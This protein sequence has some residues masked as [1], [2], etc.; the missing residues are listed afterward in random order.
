MTENSLIID[1]HILICSVGRTSTEVEPS[2]VKPHSVSRTP[3]GGEENNIMQVELDY[4]KNNFCG[5]V[6]TTIDGVIVT[7]QY[8][9]LCGDIRKNENI[10]SANVYVIKQLSNNYNMTTYNIIDIGEVP[11][12]IHNV[13]IYFRNIFNSNDKDYFNSIKTSHEFQSLTES[14]KPNSAFRTGIYLTKV[15][16]RDAE[17]KFNLLRCSSNLNGPTDNFRDIDNEIITKINTVTQIHFEQKVELNHVLAQI[18]E[19]NEKGKAKI[20]AHSDKTKDM[21]ANALMA[22]CTFYDTNLIN[23]KIKKS[24][25]DMFDY[26]Y[27]KTSVLTKLH[28]KLKYPVKYPLLAKEFSVTLYPNSAFIIS[29]TTNRLY[30][31]E[32]RPSVL[33]FNVIP[34]RMG[35][36]IRCSNTPAIF[37]DGQTWIS[38][39]DEYTPL[40]KINKD[41]ANELRTQYFKENTT[42]DIIEYAHTKFSMNSGDYLEPI[43]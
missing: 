31:H 25:T 22:F 12:N 1:K 39:N 5:I 42:D 4:L 28:F 21:P 40:E 30:T 43:F 35:Y 27:N 20:K 29:L 16:K 3:V 10:K 18:Y 37:K 23:N 7:D 17:L 36:V 8:I 11:I 6:L 9:Y 19:N 13:G 34:T 41:G 33:P 15:E 24:N 2:N 32:I 26:L 38:E 14:N